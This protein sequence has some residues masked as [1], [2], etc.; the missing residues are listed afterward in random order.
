MIAVI[1][2]LIL[3]FKNLQIKIYQLW[4]KMQKKHKV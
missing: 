1:K 4:Q 2:L 3:L